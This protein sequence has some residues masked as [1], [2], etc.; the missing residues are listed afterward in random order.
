M[1]INECTGINHEFLH[2]SG[3][4]RWGS[5]S[6]EGSPRHGRCSAALSDVCCRLGHIT[7]TMPSQ[8][9]GPKELTRQT[10]LEEN[11]R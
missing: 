2:G 6:Q 10:A 7:T 11:M 3:A 8:H 9:G 1:H 5:A 4:D